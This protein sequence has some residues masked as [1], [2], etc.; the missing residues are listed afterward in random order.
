MYA[1]SKE[2]PRHYDLHSYVTKDRSRRSI[3]AHHLS[4]YEKKPSYVGPNLSNHLPGKIRNL[5]EKML[6]RKLDYSLQ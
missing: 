4:L 5:T 3:P 6:K 2:L 1:D